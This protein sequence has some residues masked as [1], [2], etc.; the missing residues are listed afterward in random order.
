MK[1]FTAGERRGLIL[2]I[3]L[4][5]LLLLGKLW[6]DSRNR[7]GNADIG[8]SEAGVELRAVIVH[9]DSVVTSDSLG[10]GNVEKSRK[11]GKSDRKSALKR[12]STP[13]RTREPLDDALN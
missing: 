7:G 1:G 9:T 13:P 6:T 5:T 11:K 4:L 12:K 3:L 2:L 8:P 10:S